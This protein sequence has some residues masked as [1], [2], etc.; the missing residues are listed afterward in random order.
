MATV[1]A[2]Y[3]VQH[4]VGWSGI[5]LSINLAFISYDA[6]IFMIKWFDDLNEKAHFEEP[7]VPVS[8]NEDYIPVKSKFCFPVEEVEH[9]GPCKSSSKP[10][11]K[12]TFINKQK[13]DL[14][15]SIPVVKNGGNATKEMK[16]IFRCVDHYEILGF[17]RYKKINTTMLKK[18]YKKKVNF[19]FFVCQILNN[20]NPKISLFFWSVDLHFD[21][22][23]SGNAC[24]P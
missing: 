23:L 10:A 13:K 1:Y 11:V 9:V 8:F 3:N 16:R 4:Q 17:C 6:L 19:I 5:L 20:K 21:L 22:F 14:V 24:A 12:S 7:K 15:I 2:L 18:E